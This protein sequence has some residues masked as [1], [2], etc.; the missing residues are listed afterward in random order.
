MKLGTLLEK[1]KTALK[2]PVC[3]H[4]EARLPENTLQFCSR[5][6]DVLGLRHPKPVVDL[7]TFV[8]HAA[9]HFNPEVKKLLY[10][11]KFYGQ[12]GLEAQLAGLLIQYWEGL[13]RQARQAIHPENVLVLTI[14]P[15]RMG[16]SR[17]EDF[18][19]RFAR[20]F[21]YDFRPGMLLWQRRVEPQ[22]TLNDKRA[23]FANIADSL[24]VHKRGLRGHEVIVVV[25]DI[26]TT[27]ATLYEATRAL[28][29]SLAHPEQMEIITL[30][31]AKVPLGVR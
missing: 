23:R 8:C 30:A 29:Q 28:R 20:H 21:G 31:V 22:H 24:Q 27:G 26:T 7:P 17:V 10:G 13:S 25:D 11:H 9:T 1:V 18:A 15:H 14:P 6:Q 4:C 16:E 19:R 2:S 5:C 12:E 3:L